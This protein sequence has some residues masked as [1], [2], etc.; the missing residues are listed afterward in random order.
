MSSPE[1]Q[2]RPEHDE[3]SLRVVA[4]NADA[5]GDTALVP[6]TSTRPH[7]AD[8]K[9]LPA[10]GRNAGVESV[11]PRLLAIADMGSIVLALAFTIGVLHLIGQS[12]SMFRIGVTAALLMPLWFSVAYV[13][14]LYSLADLRIKQSAI[15]EMGKV[16]IA[17]TAWSWLILI[18]RTMFSAGPTT[19][20]GPTVLW[21]SVFVIVLL[22]RTAMRRYALNRFRNPTPVAI[23][24][25]PDEA[26]ILKDRIDR[27]PEWGLAIEAEFDFG[28][29]DEV[30]LQSLA[31]RISAVGPERVMIVG[32]GEGLVDRTGLVSLLVERGMM[33]DLVAGGA[34]SLFT[35][36]VLHDLEGLP[37]M[38][39]RSSR[40]KPMDLRIKRFFDVVVSVL[41]LLF[42]SPVLVITAI[43][44]RLDSPGPV[45]FKQ[46]RCGFDG[47]AFEVLKFRTM[48]DGAHEM[49]DELWKESEGEREG[50]VLFKLEN[51]PR[52][53]RIGLTLRKW[54][55]D[56]LPQLWNVL[57]GEMSI[58]GPRPLTF[59]EANH[60]RGHF[61]ARTRVKPGL[62]GPWQAYGRSSIPF[63]DMIRLD[64]SY[65]VGWSMAEDV[66]LILR[67]VIAVF[68]RRGAY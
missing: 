52:L 13:A 16:L 12:L 54:S 48:V 29:D 42:L 38:S 51:D 11:Y 25:W 30:S 53:T 22:S 9:S 5:V 7:L 20:W 55:I 21:L 64:Y 47:E 57:R 40:M 10:P 17:V 34:E 68:S 32:G 50:D 63:A 59:E 31:D 26:S 41:C 46:V 35:N 67:T 6:E 49:R 33:I 45:L 28:S 36:L 65:A 61:D 58:V 24:G 14:G 39:V 27:H 23:V 37:V 3:M 2:S 60:A 43:R 19:M 56:E 8:V 66:R 4:S 18:V 44:I 15:D 1:I 62:A